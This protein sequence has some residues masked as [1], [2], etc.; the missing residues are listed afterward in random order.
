[1]D[2]SLKS[3]I[4]NECLLFYIK[5]HKLPIETTSDLNEW[6][7]IIKKICLEDDE[8]IISI[9][10]ES[11][12]EDKINFII[13]TIKKYNKNFK[14]HSATITENEFL[15]HPFTN[16]ALLHAT[17]FI[18]DNDILK[19]KYST[20][21]NNSIYDI[22]KHIFYYEYPYIKKN[23]Y[24]LSARRY[25]VTRD[26]IFKNL[27]VVQPTG[28]IRYLNFDN[29]INMVENNL[30]LYKNTKT[31][32]EEYGESY[33]SFICETCVD[34]NRTMGK[35]IPMTEKTLLGF[36]F[37]TIPI[38]FG[39]RGLNDSLLKMG[40]WTANNLFDFDDTSDNS[41]LDFTKLVSKINDLSLLE[42]QKIY[43]D[44]ID[45]IESNYNLLIELFN[46]GRKYNTEY[47]D[48]LF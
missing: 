21:T 48:I 25:N 14:L 5:K 26:K 9:G 17:S 32:L 28:I 18:Y 13:D 34:P 38:V 46:I 23:K 11:L 27:N 42:I 15:S 43:E 39:N 36:Y 22:D 35:Y 19:E 2:I 30:N 29:P 7:T 12:Y 6:D 16:I 3:R 1:M 33:L 40:F 47:N 4:E 20:N 44:N 41:I 24:I 31:L 10:F 37:K 8:G 45:N